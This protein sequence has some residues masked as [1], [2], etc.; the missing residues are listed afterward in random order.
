MV[1]DQDHETSHL[2]GSARRRPR[3]AEAT[4]KLAGAFP[5]GKSTSP[6]EI[7]APPF[8]VMTHWAPAEPRPNGPRRAAR[9]S[10]LLSARKA[11]STV[12]TSWGSLRIRVVGDSHV[13]AVGRVK[14]RPKTRLFPIYKGWLKSWIARGVCG[15]RTLPLVLDARARHEAQKPLCGTRSCEACLYI[16][17]A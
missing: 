11:V 6:A 3:L 15:P 2:L 4:V 1:Y 5:F 9:R 14:I 13:R 16:S 17:I 8:N 12:M 7:V 10:I